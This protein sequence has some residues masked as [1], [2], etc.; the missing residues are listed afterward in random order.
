[1][2]AAP[3]YSECPTDSIKS[4]PAVLAATAS[5][6]LY[7]TVLEPLT[8]DI[9]WAERHTAPTFTGEIPGM[10]DEVGAGLT[11][12]STLRFNNNEYTIISVQLISN[13]HKAWILP[14]TNQE[15]NFEDIAIT[16]STYNDTTYYKYITFII[17]IIRSGSVEPTY[18]KGLSNNNG[19]G[20][21]SLETCF[22]TD[23]RSRF[24]YYATC[25]KGYAGYA[26]IQTM[27]VFVSIAGIQASTQLMT[28][29]RV[30]RTYGT[31]HPPFI[32]RASGSQTI[33]NGSTFTKYVY[34]TTDLLN[35]K[36]F[37]ELHP[38]IDTKVR[39]D[40]TSSYK[41]VPL[42]PDTSVIDGQ[43]N[44]D[45]TNGELLSN[46]LAK[47]DELRAAQ[48]IT[49]SMTRNP[50]EKYISIAV[51]VLLAIILIGSIIFGA[52]SYF[53][54]APAAVVGAAPI[55]IT[56]INQLPMYLILASITGFIGF[57]IGAML[58]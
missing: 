53:T 51:G 35:Y 42:D 52:I 56:W 29:L 31:Y 3:V 10:T 36:D 25:L 1:M 55:S 32:E 28:S 27:G 5:D 16:F 17:P 23:K 22:P 30:N 46:V 19:Q 8:M 9:K 11:S 15:K 37:K 41:C 54:P 33:I 45:L 4:F 57:I 38:S 50:I 7:D 6:T 48:K 18:L 39:T 13:S 49:P 14:I 40:D 2:P 12:L 24:A 20:T 21:F 58:S 43:L 47:R 34:T 44:V 26:G